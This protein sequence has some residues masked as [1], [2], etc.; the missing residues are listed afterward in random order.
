MVLCVL[1][2]DSVGYTVQER[3][4]SARTSKI[5]A[6][7]NLQAAHDENR[8]SQ[9]ITRSLGL[10]IS[11][12]PPDANAPLSIA[13]DRHTQTRVIA[14]EILAADLGRAIGAHVGS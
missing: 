4:T 2:S 7:C 3:D 6:N 14:P 8:K 1:Y 11:D 13:G 5:T 12:A 10:F 9:Y